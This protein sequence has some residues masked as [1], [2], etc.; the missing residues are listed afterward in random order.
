[1][2]GETVIVDGCVVARAH[3]HVSLDIVGDNRSHPRQD[4]Q[5]IIER[6][7]LAGRACWRQYVR[8]DELGA[9]Y[10]SARAF[11]FLSEYE[12]FGFTPLEALAAGVPSVQLDT[13]VAREMCGDAALYVPC[14]DVPATARALER[15]LFDEATRGRIREAAP[16]VLARYG[17]P[18]A[19]RETLGVIEACT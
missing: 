13:A 18:S 6:E 19:A 7:G 8:D 4:V 9:L 3:A 12:G 5:G 2:F 17:W 10:A 15:L 14:G 16:S 1:V 11:V